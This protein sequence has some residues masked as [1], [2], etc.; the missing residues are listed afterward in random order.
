MT[1]LI[2][3]TGGTV[4]IEVRELSD[5]WTI[6][7][8]HP[9]APPIAHDWP[10]AAAV[11][12]CVHADLLRAGLIPDPTLD[13]NEVAVQWVGNIAWRYDLSFDVSE[14]TFAAQHHQLAFDGLDTLATITLN[15]DDV[16]TTE[17]M[18]RRYRFDV[19]D[20]LILGINTVTIVFDSAAAE[21]DRRRADLGYWPSASFDQPFNMVRKM[22]CAWG[23]DWGLQLTTAGI[24]RAARLES[25]SDGRL[26]SVRPQATL[27]PFGV[28]ELV[29]DIDTE[30]PVS[31]LPGDHRVVVEIAGGGADPVGD[32]RPVE[33]RTTRVVVHLPT[34]QSWWPRDR[35]SQQLYDLRVELRDATGRVIDRMLTRV[36]FRDIRVDT[37][38]DPSGGRPFTVV[39]NDRPVFIRGVNW[40]PDDIMVTE[41][42]RE[43]YAARL[44][45]IVELG[46]NLVRVWGG[47]IYES[48]DF[49]ELCDERGLLVWQDF[50]FAC[51][52]YPEEHLTEEVAAEARDNVARLMHHP[53]LAVWCGN[54][55][56]TWGFADW[57]WPEQLNGRAWGEGWYREL[58][59]AIVA[60]MDPGRPYTDGS[61]SSTDTSRPPNSDDDG[62]THIWDVW[63]QIDYRHYRDKRPRFVSE[64]GWQAPPTMATLTAAISDDPM[65]PESPGIQHHQKAEGGNAK[66]SAGLKPFF[67]EPRDLDEWLW[68]MQLNQAR[69]IRTG[70]EWFRSLH[71][72]CM[73][74]IWWQHNDC[75]P[76]ISWSVLDSSGRRKP[77]WYALQASYRPWLL[78]IQPTDESLDLVAVND[79]TQS[80]RSTVVVT[81]RGFDGKVRAEQVIDVDAPDG[82]ARSLR[83]TRDV[84]VPDDP[85]GEFLCVDDPAGDGH[86]R[87]TWFYAPDRQLALPPASFAVETVV[88]GDDL[89]VGV[90]AD[91]LLVDLALLADRLAPQVSVDDQL[92]LV[93]PGE[94]ATFRLH[95][96]ACIDPAKVDSTVLRTANDLVGPAPP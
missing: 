95:G 43:R 67:D 48:E 93:L 59:P 82:T 17:N 88:E 41:V 83:L 2:G 56:N 50:A 26:A 62:T 42:T 71:G 69:A 60:E 76:V 94:T 7:P 54:N 24:W 34:V 85:N 31:T 66:L 72:R 18:H 11:P 92:R 19:S 9:T 57:G 61:P 16:A 13:D 10:I 70:V 36:G 64:F 15:G 55:E 45:D 79:T 87:S 1:E 73:G 38:P 96:G 35:G 74:T 27:R 77:S 49:Y 91:C 81:R 30:R 4:P 90:T 80:V 33:G 39:V 52:A 12:G 78:T 84:Q 8:L 29:V 23:W 46:A 5:G 28:G 51:A 3:R 14:S 21:A 58:L 68:A 6:R 89:L 47:G 65:T 44:D 63:N 86:R 37:T 22:A 32:S 40:I 25:W 75:W 20:R 53:S